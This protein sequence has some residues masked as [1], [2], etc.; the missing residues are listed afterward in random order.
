MVEWKLI[1]NHVGGVGGGGG[2]IACLPP[3]QIWNNSCLSVCQHLQAR[4]ESE[5]GVTR[6]KHQWAIVCATTLRSAKSYSQF[7]YCKKKRKSCVAVRLPDWIL[8][9]CGVG[10]RAKQ[11]TL[12]THVNSLLGRSVCKSLRIQ[13][14]NRSH[15]I[16]KINK[17]WKMALYGG[18]QC[19]VSKITDSLHN[20]IVDIKKMV[21]FNSHDC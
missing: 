10:K 3:I 16:K 17:Y 18:F 6:L 8:G 15:E 19:R 7:S 11:T 20:S 21:N 1:R 5:A 2:G 9:G 4:R 13:L 14:N 12:Q